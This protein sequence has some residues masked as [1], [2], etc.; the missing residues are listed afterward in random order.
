MDGHLTTDN[1][2]QE[3]AL[4]A[5]LAQ[6]AQG[7][8]TDSQKLFAGYDELSVS[9]DEKAQTL[10]CRLTPTGGP[11]FTPRLLAE[12]LRLHGDIERLGKARVQATNPLRFLIATSGIEGIFN[13]GGDLAHFAG[14]IRRRDADGLRRYAYDCVQVGYNNAFGYA[15]PIVTVAVLQG[16]TLGGG[17]EAALGFQILV[18]ERGVRMGLPEILFNAFP[19]MG[20]YSLLSRKL[21][22]ARAKQIILSGKIYTAEEFHA[23]GLVHVL[24]E[25]G[26]GLAVAEDF[27]RRNLKR[28]SVHAALARMERRMFGIT[29]EELR[30][31]ADIWVETMLELRSTDLRKMERLTQAQGARTARA[32]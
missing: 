22:P 3:N 23:M 12:L 31:I 30:A 27:V 2:G 6:G 4:S 16:D 21:D 1:R 28:A 18:A 29:L 9:I 20:A 14:C 13:L 8:E 26:Q 15:S 24:A 25:P 7:A 11:C 5:I 32:S 10:Y 17:L 19:G